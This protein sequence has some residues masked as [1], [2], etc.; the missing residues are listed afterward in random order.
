MTN[1]EFGKMSK[2]IDLEPRSIMKDNVMTASASGKQAD[3][4]EIRPM[5]DMGPSYTFT[6]DQSGGGPVNY[7]FR[8]EIEGIQQAD[9]FECTGLGSSIEVVPYCSSTDPTVHKLP[10]KAAYSEIKIRWGVNNESQHLY[11]W[12]KKALDGNAER[13]NVSIVMFDKSGKDTAR[14][15]LTDVWPSAYEGPDL[16]TTGTYMAFESLTL[17]CGRM[18]RVR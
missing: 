15:N 10:G 17:V 2:K 12:H 14:W 8:I 3:N 9:F 11:E 13:R 5:T 18:E 16:N 1:N 4:I 6:A 7:R